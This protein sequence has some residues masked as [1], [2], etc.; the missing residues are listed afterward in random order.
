MNNT[1]VAIG[2][3]DNCC[4]VWDITDKFKPSLRFILPHSAAVK[5][6]A[7]CPWTK[8]LLVTGGGTKDRNIRFWHTSSG[9]LLSSHYTKG[10]VTSLHWSIFRKEIVATY[11]FGD[12][13]S[14]LILA[15]YSYP[16]MAPLLI[17]P[18]SP[19]LRILSASTSP[20]NDSICVATND[21]T[22]RM[23]KLWSLSHELTSNPIGL[24]SGIYG[25]SLID[26]HEGMGHTGDTIR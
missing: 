9:T 23:Y 17:V 18:A 15:K 8:S 3:N 13:D 19:S 25:S 5:A 2:A 7:Y 10:Q 12:S 6:M 21:S 20:N 4:T 14:P 11:G 24:G 1:E 26:L 16:N 22:V